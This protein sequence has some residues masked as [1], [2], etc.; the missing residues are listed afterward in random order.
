MTI[1]EALRLRRSVR[2]YHTTPI[3]P[4]ALHAL[5][6]EIAAINRESGLHFQLITDEPKAFDSLLA[7]YGKFSGV[8]NYIA[9]VGKKSPDLFEKCGYYGQRL[10]LRAQQL[11][12]DTC[13]VA[14]TYRRI[15]GTIKVNKGEKLTV[16]IS[17]G[18]GTT[19]G[20]RRPSK[21]AQQV[22]DV[23]DTCPNWYKAGV[24]GA[25]LAPTAINQQKFRITRSGENVFFNALPGPYSKMDL[26][27]VKYN[28]EI[29]SGRRIQP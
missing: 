11:G 26:G 17:V 9:L 13:W 15:P 29:A 8:R 23:T 14:L 3:A 5:R 10:V 20:V 2:S 6:E 21:T 16:V 28:F 27:I 22:S 18:Y 7:H 12:L 24:E 25:L 4:D 1:Q 19:Q